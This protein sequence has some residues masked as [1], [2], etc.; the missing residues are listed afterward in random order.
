MEGSKRSTCW[1]LTINNPTKEDFDAVKNHAGWKDFI[2]FEGQV[3]E[4]ENGTPHIQGM[5]VTKSCKFSAVKKYYPRAH[6]EIA[7]NKPALTNYVNKEETRIAELP[8]TQVATVVDLN[9]ALI[10]ILSNHEDKDIRLSTEGWGFECIPLIEKRYGEDAGMRLL[11]MCVEYLIDTDH[12]GIEYIGANP[13][14]RATWKKYW[15]S[16]LKREFRNYQKSLKAV[17]SVRPSVVE[18]SE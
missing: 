3:E 12:Y 14:I 6:I 10:D 9:S 11:D 2:R 8:K 4:G 7:R 17:P 15:K 13:S 18:E 1:S 16:I 5:L